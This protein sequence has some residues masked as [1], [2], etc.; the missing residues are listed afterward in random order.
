MPGRSSS[1]VKAIDA[2]ILAREGEVEWIRED[3]FDRDRIQVERPSPS[4]SAMHLLSAAQSAK[5]TGTEKSLNQVVARR[6]LGERQPC[7]DGESQECRT[8]G[9]R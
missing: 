9:L 3:I 8:D 5:R 6:P 7:D 1:D 4:A 2:T